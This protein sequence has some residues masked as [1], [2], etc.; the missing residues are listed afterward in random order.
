MHLRKKKQ[1]VYHHRIMEL[2]PE[3]FLHCGLP[4]NKHVETRLQEEQKSKTRQK[5][6]IQIPV[7]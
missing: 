7:D 3:C 5:K 6:N 2:S 1:L 4:E